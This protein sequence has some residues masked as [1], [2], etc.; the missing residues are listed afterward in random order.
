MECRTHEIGV[1]P[2]FFEDMVEPC[3]T[4]KQ[5][6]YEIREDIRDVEYRERGPRKHYKAK[7][8]INTSSSSQQ[9][10]ESENQM[11]DDVSF[12]FNTSIDD[13]ISTKQI[14]QQR[15]DYENLHDID[16]IDQDQ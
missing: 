10:D 4:P 7:R 6:T 2:H 12:I 1:V 3:K 15:D 14:N 16:Q 5:K 9:D 8:E 13:G 11:E